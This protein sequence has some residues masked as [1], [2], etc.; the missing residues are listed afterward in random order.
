MFIIYSSC[1]WA[2]CGV[3]NDA[4]EPEQVEQLPPARLHCHWK[5]NPNASRE[6]CRSCAGT[7]KDAGI[8][9]GKQPTD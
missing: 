2:I 7:T 3:V 5:Q 6:A 9:R 8:K 1:G 4:P